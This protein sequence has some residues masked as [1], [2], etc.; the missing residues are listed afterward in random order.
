MAELFRLVNY[1]DLS[2]TIYIYYIY[3]I[4]LLL[5]FIIIYIYIFTVYI[6][7]DIMH[8]HP[9]LTLYSS[10]HLILIVDQPPVFG[11]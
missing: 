6:N 7:S 8:G 1:L 11:I 4:I 10:F 2:M 5:L 3:I 9:W